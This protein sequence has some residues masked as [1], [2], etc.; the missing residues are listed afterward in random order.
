MAETNIK[1]KSSAQVLGHSDR[2]PSFE[3]KELESQT[4]SFLSRLVPIECP[5]LAGHAPKTLNDGSC[6]W[7]AGLAFEI[8]QKRIDCS[9]I[10]HITQIN[11]YTRVNYKQKTNKKKQHET[12]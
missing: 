4:T 8:K 12:V 5:S 1:A 7:H 11:Y 10:D 9:I 3:N 2:A 6:K